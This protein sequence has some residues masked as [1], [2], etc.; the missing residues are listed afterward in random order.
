ML[1]AWQG[2]EVFQHHLSIIGGIAN[3]AGCDAP[4]AGEMGIAWGDIGTSDAGLAVDAEEALLPTLAATVASRPCIVNCISTGSA[5]LR[6][7][8]CLPMV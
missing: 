5:S 2:A 6:L 7:S 1:S 4:A 8:L 3:I